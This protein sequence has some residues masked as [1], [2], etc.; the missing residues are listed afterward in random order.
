MVASAMTSTVAPPIAAIHQGA[1]SLPMTRGL[2]AIITINAWTRVGVA[3][4]MMPET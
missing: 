3:T 4:E 2:M 1:V